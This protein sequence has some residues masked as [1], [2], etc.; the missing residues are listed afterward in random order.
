[1]ASR[2][3]LGVIFA[4]FAVVCI[5]GTQPCV[6]IPSE[7]VDV[8]SALISSASFLNIALFGLG[9]QISAAREK[10]YRLNLI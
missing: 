8:I 4:L 2:S 9:D 10:F 3:R 6:A 1:M 7:E 5:F